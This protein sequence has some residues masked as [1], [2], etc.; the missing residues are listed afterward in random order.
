MSPP[1]S[2]RDRFAELVGGDDD[3]INLAEAALLIAAEA[4]PGLDVARYVGAL[5]ALAIEAEPLVRG[6][7]TNPE[8]VAPAG[9]VPRRRA[10]AFAATRTTTTTAATAF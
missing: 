7:G 1:R 6:S 3:G 8:Q 4:Y 5:D 9:A 2:A 10:A